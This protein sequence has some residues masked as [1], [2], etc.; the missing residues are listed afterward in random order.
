[1]GTKRVLKRWNSED[2]Q[3]LVAFFSMDRSREEKDVFAKRL[4]RTWGAIY[5]RHWDM[6]NPDSKERAKAKAKANAKSR[7]KKLEAQEKNEKLIVTHIQATATP[8]M[9]TIK[10][11]EC[12]IETYS[13]KIRINNVLI[14]V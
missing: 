9:T 13:S 4:G 7:A 11:G 2:N 10:I 3:E 12:I 6:K 1:M 5:N 8:G 14:E